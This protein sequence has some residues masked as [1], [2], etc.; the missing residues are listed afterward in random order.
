M[1]ESAEAAAPEE[2]PP[3]PG[4]AAPEGV[5]VEGS[6]VPGRELTRRIRHTAPAPA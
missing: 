3:Q 2:D 1:A 4:S 5:P 6:G